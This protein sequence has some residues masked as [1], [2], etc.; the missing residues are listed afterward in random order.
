MKIKTIDFLYIFFICSFTFIYFLNFPLNVDSTWILYS[1]E[2][3]LLGDLLFVEPSNA[4]LP[5]NFFY[6]AFCVILSKFLPFS[7]ANIY[8]IFV[9][10]II[11]TS[12]F[13]SYKILLKV[14][15][16]R[17][18]TIRYYLYILSISF[19]VFVLPDFGERGHLFIVSLIPYILMMMNK[20][21]IKLENKFIV[22]ISLLAAFG[23][24]IKPHFV[25]VLLSIELIYLIHKKKISLLFRLDIYIIAFISIIHLF[26]LLYMFPQ[27]LNFSIPLSLNAYANAFNKPLDVL[28]FQLDIILLFISLI[29]WI[30]FSKREFNL[31][32]KILFTVLITTLAI[33]LIQQKGWFYHRLPLFITTILFI[34]YISLQIKNFSKIYIIGFL[35]FIISIFINNIQSHPRFNNLEKI[36]NSLPKGNAIH[37]LSSDIAQGQALLVKNKQQWA[38]R[39]SAFFMTKAVV[40][41]KNEFVKKYLFESLE[42]DIYKFKTDNIIFCKDY[43]NF[44][45]YNFIRSNK[46]INTLLTKHYKK[47]IIEKCIVLSKIKEFSK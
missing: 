11:A 36:L 44:N 45:Y 14:Y 27:W 34:I 15:P 1:A 30:A 28:I 6:S 37:I 24:N 26:I 5:I 25:L 41:E 47:E 16:F 10:L 2:R 32:I 40:V 17:G 3:L 38:S 35:P 20:D 19:T 12:L 29:L 4:D 46:I 22:L 33:Y 42:K 43:N 31:P 9:L 7:V 8:I 21:T 23:F 18:D 13:L 39:F